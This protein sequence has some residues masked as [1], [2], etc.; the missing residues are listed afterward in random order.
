MLRLPPCLALPWHSLPLT[1][2]AATTDERLPVT[3]YCN[4][5]AVPLREPAATVP[6][7]RLSQSRRCNPATCCSGDWKERESGS[8][9]IIDSVCV[10]CIPLLISLPL[11]S[12]LFWFEASCP[13]LSPP[14][15]TRFSKVL[16]RECGLL[17]TTHIL[18]QSHMQS[19]SQ[20][21]HTHTVM[22]SR[23]Q[24]T[25]GSVSERESA[26]GRTVT[27]PVFLEESSRDR[28]ARRRRSHQSTV[29]SRS[30]QHACRDED[31]A[32]RRAIATTIF[33]Q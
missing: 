28:A 15:L 6:I 17:C 19:Q 4:R 14:L 24:R 10:N 5:K 33:V 27:A 32:S 25:M 7:P 31:D 13:L 30:T 23:R 20:Q 22:Q 3:L 16:R 18:S 11:L 21:T 12:L 8:R 2:A 29:T 26:Q 1:L 9:L